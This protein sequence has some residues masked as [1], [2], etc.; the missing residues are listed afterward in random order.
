MLS[1]YVYTSHS[2]ILT[3]FGRFASIFNKMALIFLEVPI[4]FNVSSFTKSN[5]R[6]FIANNEWSPN[7]SDLNP[8]A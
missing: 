1:V 7:S 8:L 5:R 2:H 3:N 6:D 4:I